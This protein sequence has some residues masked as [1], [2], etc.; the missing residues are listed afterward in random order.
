MASKKE[1]TMHDVSVLM[2]TITVDLAEKWLSESNRGNR[3]LSE[4][5]VNRYMRDMLAGNWKNAGDPIRFSDTGRLLDGQH[6]LWAL[7]EADDKRL[8]LEKKG[9][10]KKSPPITFK[11]IIIGGL[12]DNSQLVMDQGL[13]RS[14]G[15]QLTLLGH[16]HAAVLASASTALFKMQRGP[17][18]MTARTN[19]PSN[20]EMLATLKAH[21]GLIEAVNQ[22]YRFRA[23]AGF[24]AGAGA[25]CAVFYCMR[26]HDL[27]KA[28]KFVEGY[29]NGAG[30]PP[31]HPALALRERISKLRM[32]K[33]RISQRDMAL[34][35]VMGWKAH[36]KGKKIVRLRVPQ[37]FPAEFPGCPDSWKK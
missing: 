9:L 32:A 35:L 1:P 22:Y 28:N 25:F 16:K 19:A 36:C 2:Q 8:A 34:A 7:I 27:H 12:S 23:S 15:N 11:A 31:K 5:R 20:S 14:K 21:P 26:R 33:A 24:R 3:N 10:R 18:G 30:L 13:N 37:E 6:R 29:L 4:K 17:N